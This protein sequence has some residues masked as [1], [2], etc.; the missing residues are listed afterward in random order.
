LNED[1]GGTPIPP[2]LGDPDPED[3]ITLAEARLFCRA[4][5]NDELLSKCQ[6]LSDERGTIGEQYSKN[7]PEDKQQSHSRPRPVA[8][9]GILT[10]RDP[11]KGHDA[12]VL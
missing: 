10:E 1:E 4:T 9:S 5:E 3:A 6:V 7:D 8:E 12:E 11:A 2:Q